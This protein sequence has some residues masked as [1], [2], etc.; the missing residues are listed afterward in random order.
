MCRACHVP[1][2]PSALETPS[3]FLSPAGVLSPSNVFSP[4]ASALHLSS[5]AEHHGGSADM[6]PAARVA[7]TPSFGKL[8]LHVQEAAEKDA[9][10]LNDDAVRGAA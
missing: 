7:A 6:S 10:V 4:M 8:M 3:G 2:A 1:S 9:F 5:M